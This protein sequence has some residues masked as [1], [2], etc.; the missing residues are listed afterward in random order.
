[1]KLLCSVLILIFSIANYECA[2]LRV[3]SMLEF[4]FQF[5]SRQSSD[6]ERDLQQTIPNMLDEAEKGFTE[7]KAVMDRNN[8]VETT[9]FFDNIE[10]YEGALGID[11]VRADEFEKQ[12]IGENANEYNAE[13]GNDLLRNQPDTGAYAEKASSSD[14]DFDVHELPNL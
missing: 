4:D 11:E 12:A 13:N 9:H 3:Q 14:G 1:M 8:H 10:K 7:E 5:Y 2:R 6:F